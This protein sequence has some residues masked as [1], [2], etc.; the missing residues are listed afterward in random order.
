L[1]ALRARLVSDWRNLL[2]ERFDEEVLLTEL[3]KLGAFAAT[4]RY[5][6]LHAVHGDALKHHLDWLA[7][8]GMVT[9]LLDA[10]SAGVTPVPLG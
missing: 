3:R 6:R 4:E 2:D 9:R 5:D 8:A 10:E 7:C 1:R